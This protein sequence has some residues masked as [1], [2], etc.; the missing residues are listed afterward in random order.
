MQRLVGVTARSGLIRS[1][2]LATVVAITTAATSGCH[3]LS[4]ALTAHVDVA[5]RAGKEQLQVSRLATLLGQSRAPLQKE[6]ARQLALLWVDYQLLG[7]AAANDDSLN[8]PK[9]V[10]QAL[11]P[12]YANARAK[13]WVDT[14]T[15]RWTGGDS[16]QLATRYARG[17][18]LA[19]W[20][21]LIT[22]KDTSAPHLDSA[23]R[24]A[25]AIR[26]EATP[27]NF[28]ALARKNS[29]DPG[30]APRGGD[31][32][33]FN[34]GQMVPAFEQGLVALSP[35]QISQP[36]RTQF[37]Y[38]VIYRPTYAQVHDQVA[39]VLEQETLQKAESAYVVALDSAAHMEIA[40]TGVATVRAVAKDLDGHKTDQTTIVTTSYGPVTAAGL[41]KWLAIFP[42]TVRA[43]LPT[44]P[45]SLIPGFL[46]NI[47]RNE[48]MLHQADSAHITLDS[49]E[50][51]KIRQSYTQLVTNAW[52]QLGLDPKE[53]AD[54][55]KTPA[56][57]ERIAA[58][59][60]ESFL[61][62]LFA[63]TPSAR[64]VDI[65]QP[66]E[67]VLRGKYD[68]D[69]S[70]VG[71]D[72]ALSDATS[73]RHTADSTRAAKEPASAV[74]LPGGAGSSL[75]P[76]AIPGGASTPAEAPAAKP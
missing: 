30:S 19:A 48:E 52:T 5:A 59:H 17:D 18:A 7:L 23:R 60:V 57:R 36:I 58:A 40:K 41:A 24:K 56:E 67:N 25:A 74:P 49:A 29:Q 34:K 13:H 47:V 15:K 44:A 21:I 62:R 64:F 51:T 6:F 32:G 3:G 12:I 2:C 8:E 20:H 1:A 28:A 66:L 65:P 4:E 26:A 63:A 54:S 35:G 55:A 61:D 16:S 27:A 46:R 69:V 43:Q 37:G 14:L 75:R 76:G 22:T 73:I 9:L 68:S 50:I 71:L 70:D 33:V 11:W 38:H 45:D 53:L 42:Q 31:L 10:D 39:K 72:R